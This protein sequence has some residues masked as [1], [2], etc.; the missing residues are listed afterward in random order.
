MKKPFTKFHIRW[1]E[2][3]GLDGNPYMRRYVI[4]MWLFSIR[5]HVW[6]AGDD[7]RY[8]HDHAFDFITLVLKGSYTDV[9][10]DGNELLT[11]GS[12]RYR[13]AE[14]SHYVSTPKAPTVTLLLCFR[15]RRNWGFM[16]N[17]KFMRPLRYFS[18]YGHE[19]THKY[20]K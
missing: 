19:D 3:L 7:T 8:M 13:T 10:K 18:R 2:P 5:L 1:N 14:H 4:N 20:Q 15:P 16:V 9:T 6:Y 17:N 11:A 12:I